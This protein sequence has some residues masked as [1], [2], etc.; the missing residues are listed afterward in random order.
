MAHSKKT[1]F[2]TP[3]GLLEA[4]ILYA[5]CFFFVNKQSRSRQHKKYASNSQKCDIMNMLIPRLPVKPGA[6]A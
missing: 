4:E 1:S 5:A 3:F 6:I 2:G